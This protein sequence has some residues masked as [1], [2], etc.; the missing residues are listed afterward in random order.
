[1]FGCCLL[2]RPQIVG[3]I[4]CSQKHIACCQG[5]GD[6]IKARKSLLV[7][8]QPTTV[9]HHPKQAE[10]VVPHQHICS[11][12]HN[13]LGIVNDEAQ[14]LGFRPAPKKRAY[15]FGHQFCAP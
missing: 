14:P 5:T 10:V 3:C 12:G 1:M 9:L 13:A 7:C 8:M 4:N 6:C 15:L 11:R 2:K